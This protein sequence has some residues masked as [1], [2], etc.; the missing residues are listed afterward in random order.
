MWPGVGL[1]LLGPVLVL[2]DGPLVLLLLPAHRRGHLR[3]RG[4]GAGSGSVQEGSYLLGPDDLDAV[5]PAGGGHGGR[6]Q[7]GGELGAQ[8]WRRRRQP[9]PAV[10]PGVGVASCLDK[11][12]NETIDP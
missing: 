3:G 1:G 8:E 11:D 5:E 7:Q 9:G 4:P 2:H 12:P 10:N 6:A